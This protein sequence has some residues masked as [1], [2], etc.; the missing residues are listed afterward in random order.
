MKKAGHLIIIYFTTLCLSTLTLAFLYMVV[1]T[2]MKMVAGYPIHIFSVYLFREGCLIFFSFS[3]VL[4]LLVQLLSAIKYED[5]TV[6]SFLTALFFTLFTWLLLLPISFTYMPNNSLSQSNKYST[7]LSS[8]LFRIENNVPV[9][10]LDANKNGSYHVLKIHK[11]IFLGSPIEED[12]AYVAQKKL[13]LDPLLEE[14]VGYPKRI[15]EPVNKVILFYI[16]AQT[17]INSGKV[18]WLC[19]ASIGLSLFSLWF[20]AGASEW[21]MVN[22]IFVCSMWLFLLFVQVEIYTGSQTIDLTRK[23]RQFISLPVNFEQFV[24][25]VL[26]GFSAIIFFIV[27][28]VKRHNRIVGGEEK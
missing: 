26:Y 3:A 4:A 20:F 14:S 27:G 10:Y 12:F 25:V 16:L 7:L 6:L 23:L 22:A 15:Q 18:A 21:K 2:C 9:Y 1:Q 8:N 13:F 28:F 24:P 11:D 5:T 19:F 17:A